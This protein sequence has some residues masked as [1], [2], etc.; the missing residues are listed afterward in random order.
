MVHRFGARG[1]RTIRAVVR[2]TRRTRGAVSAPTDVNVG[3]VLAGIHKI[4]HVVIIMQENRSFD[5]Y[6]G[7]YPGADGLPRDAQGN[8][9][10]CSPDP[11]TG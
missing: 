2:A 3:V 10:V 1:L 5:S 4:R 8:F 6:F 7:T 9:T 11:A